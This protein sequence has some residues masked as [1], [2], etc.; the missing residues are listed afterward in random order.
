MEV[1]YEAVPMFFEEDGAM[2]YS[3]TVFKFERKEIDGMLH[4]YEDSMRLILE[5]YK[6]GNLAKTQTEDITTFKELTR[7]LENA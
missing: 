4:V 3:F 5:H 2:T 7:L 6:N 1:Q